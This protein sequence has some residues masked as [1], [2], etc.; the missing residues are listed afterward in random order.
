MSWGYSTGGQ[1]SNPY[2]Q[3]RPDAIGFG[4]NGGGNTGWENRLGDSGRYYDYPN[5][6]QPYDGFLRRGFNPGYEQNEL[7]NT[8]SRRRMAEA[9]IDT[10]GKVGF[11]QPRI[12]CYP[13][14][15][16]NV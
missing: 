10:I 11:W 14:N 3:F 1:G 7:I 5:Q 2:V 9:K 4:F 16:Y 13:L 6:P 12:P 8:R 15:L